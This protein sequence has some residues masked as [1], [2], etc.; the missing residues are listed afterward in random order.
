MKHSITYKGIRICP[1]ASLHVADAIQNI[2]AWLS[3]LG[4]I[5]FTA[6]SSKTYPEK[7]EVACSL[8]PNLCGHWFPDFDTSR[9]CLT[10]AL[11]TLANEVDLE[12]EI[13]LCMLSSPVEFVFPNFQ[14]FQAAVHVRRNIVQAARRTT[15]AFDTS[16]AERPAEY[17]QYCEGRGF[18]LLPGASLQIALEKA[19]Q[20]EPG[21][22]PF[23]FS[24][25]RATEYVIL[26]GIAKELAVC[27]P[28]LLK[29]I[30]RHWEHAAV[31]S[32][33]FHDSFLIEYGSADQPMPKKFYVP[34][35]R[36]WFR[37]PDPISSDIAGYEGSWVIYLGN[38]R[39]S[40]FWKSS[41]TFTLESKCMEL[42]HWRSG[43][44]QDALGTWSM[45]ESTVE[46]LVQLTAEDETQK[47]E[48]L[49]VMMRYRDPKGVC[50]QGGCID[51]TRECPRLICQG[52]ENIALPILD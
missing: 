41:N 2:E 11:D 39:F 7:N 30:E 38:G 47:K 52:T 51:T 49:K 35:D 28:S 20:P 42:Y 44:W 36:V 21:G 15:L 48:I 5:D 19:T 16:S 32:A 23:S 24:C 43:A 46:R 45:D 37:N 6:V 22:L 10:L 25:Y 18:T 4:L 3:R 33:K 14:E 50:A 8:A 1:V 17:W 13:L 31:M 27:N 40:D 9:V 29:K 26:L 12:R 34:G